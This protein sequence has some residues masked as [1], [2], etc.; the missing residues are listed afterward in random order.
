MMTP[1]RT[2]ISTM[3]AAFVSAAYIGRETTGT[4]AADAMLN[5]MPHAYLRTRLHEILAGRGTVLIVA[6]FLAQITAEFASDLI[7]QRHTAQHKYGAIEPEEAALGSVA[8][9]AL[10]GAEDAIQ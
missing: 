1:A 10:L 6:E 9:S 7:V 4:T 5:A 3:Y 8:I 2:T